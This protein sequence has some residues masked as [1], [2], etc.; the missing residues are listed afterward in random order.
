MSRHLTLTELD[1]ARPGT[2]VIDEDG[3]VLE[4]LADGRWVVVSVPE[5]ADHTVGD[6]WPSRFLRARLFWN[7][8]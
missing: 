7:R 2:R 6:I 8:R 3:D 4:R 5:G 1:A